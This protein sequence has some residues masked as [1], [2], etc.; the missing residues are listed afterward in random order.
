MEKNS[1]FSKL[2]KNSKSKSKEEVGEIFQLADDYNAER[3]VY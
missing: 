2:V 1:D 3:Y